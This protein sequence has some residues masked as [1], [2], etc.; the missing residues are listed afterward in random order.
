M[1]CLGVGSGGRL[2]FGPFII[3]LFLVGSCGCTRGLFPSLRRRGSTWRGAYN[4][5]SCKYIFIKPLIS[6]PGGKKKAEKSEAG[7]TF[8]PK[9]NSHE[10]SLGE[11]SLRPQV[12]TQASG[13]S[14]L[15]VAASEARSQKSRRLSSHAQNY[16][17]HAAPVAKPLAA[18]TPCGKAPSN[19]AAVWQSPWQPR[20]RV[21]KPWNTNASATACK[22]NHTSNGEGR[23]IRRFS[24]CGVNFVCGQSGFE[25]CVGWNIRLQKC[26]DPFKKYAANPD[27]V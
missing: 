9:L 4:F 6:R 1:H 14:S 18:R 7:P 24:F 15:Q 23:E 21:A 19:H 2:I 16:V 3:I 22:N 27:S 12:S 10:P 26:W 17:Y 5:I 8:W 13:L 25:A 20:H 11:G